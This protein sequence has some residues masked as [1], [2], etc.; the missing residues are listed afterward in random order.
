MLKASRILFIISLCTMFYQAR[1]QADDCARAKIVS[2][3]VDDG[4]NKQWARVEVEY[5]GPFPVNPNAGMYVTVRVG[6]KYDTASGV[7]ESSSYN[8]FPV[9]AFKRGEKT[10]RVEHYILAKDCSK[11]KPCRIKDMN[12]TVAYCSPNLWDL[13]AMKR[14]DNRSGSLEDVHPSF[15]RLRVPDIPAGLALSAN[16]YLESKYDT[17]SRIARTD[18]SGPYVLQI[19]RGEKK[20]EMEGYIVAQDCSKDR[21]CTIKDFRTRVNACATKYLYTEALTDRPFKIPSTVG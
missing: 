16:V 3:W 18:S 17:A 2:M 12:V 19:G 8:P 14:K 7:A 21:P 15:S 20:T 9:A 13:I 6:S 10:Q 1:V 11:E 5:D 4:G